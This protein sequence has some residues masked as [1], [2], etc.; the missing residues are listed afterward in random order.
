M[1]KFDPYSPEVDAIRSRV[2][3][4]AR[5]ISLFLEPGGPTLDPV[6]LCGYLAAGWIGRPIPRPRA[7]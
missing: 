1:F 3:D 2:S 4:A 6:A 7:I 5:G